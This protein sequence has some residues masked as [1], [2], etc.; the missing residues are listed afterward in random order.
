MRCI[1]SQQRNITYVTYNLKPGEEG[2]YMYL[3]IWR[4]IS[5]GVLRLILIQNTVN[6]R[7]RHGTV[8][9]TPFW[10]EE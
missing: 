5:V 9:K 8:V 10:A 4:I 1:I 7:S 2:A 3:S 6:T